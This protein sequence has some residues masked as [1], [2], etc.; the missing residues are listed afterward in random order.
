MQAPF[1]NTYCRKER[2]QWFFHV[3]QPTPYNPD[4]AIKSITFFKV[5]RL[6]ITVSDWSGSFQRWSCPP[7]WEHQFTVHYFVTESILLTLCPG[8]QF[9][10]EMNCSA[11]HRVVAAFIGIYLFRLKSRQKTASYL[12][13]FKP[14]SKESRIKKNT[15]FKLWGLQVVKIKVLRLC[16]VYILPSKT[17]ALDTNQGLG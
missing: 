14:H 15:C 1:D 12:V 2:S 16:W 5:R 9:S 7:C 11:E 10:T 13:C 17:K 3:C 6:I 4:I 8:R